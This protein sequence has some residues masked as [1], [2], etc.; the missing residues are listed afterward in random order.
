LEISATFV[1]LGDS[2]YIV[3]S[4]VDP[5][6]RLNLEARL[7]AATHEHLGFQRLVSDLAARFAGVTSEAL[8]ELIV[9]SLRQIGE[10]LQLDRA[11]L[12]RWRIGEG[13]AAATHYWLEDPHQPPPGPYAIA[14][15]PYVISTLQAGEV[16][17]F[18]SLDDLP[19]PIDRE[20]LGQ[21]GSRS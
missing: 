9:T 19:D 4:I 10:A 13:S 6:E 8:D 1:Q 15:I 7:A 20:T 5:T 3:A 12:W 17:A 2:R 18:A 16:V 11:V 14:S 21:G